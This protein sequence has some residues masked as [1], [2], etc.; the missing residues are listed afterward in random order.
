[1]RS[2]SLPLMSQ[3]WARKHPFVHSIVAAMCDHRSLSS[4]SFSLDLR[5]PNFISFSAHLNRFCLWFNCT[6]FGYLWINIFSFCYLK[7]CYNQLLPQLYAIP[8]QRW[9]ASIW[10]Y[11]QPFGHWNGFFTFCSFK[12]SF[13]LNSAPNSA[14]ENITSLHE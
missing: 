13:S 8:L 7:V 2:E 10:V 9:L 14:F 1:V 12:L 4:R 11:S 6:W 3:F 5:V